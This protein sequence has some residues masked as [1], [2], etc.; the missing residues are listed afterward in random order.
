MIFDIPTIIIIVTI[1]FA[2]LVR[3]ATGFGFALVA[4]PILSFFLEP[5]EAVAY[6][7]IFQTISTLPIAFINFHKK[8]WKYSIKLLSFSLTGLIPSVILLIYIP[9][10]IVYALVAICVLVA[11]ILVATGVKIKSSL[12]LYHWFLVGFIA[13]FMHGLAGV[14]GPPILAILHADD[15]LSKNSKRQVMAIFFLFAGLLSLIPILIH[16]PDVLFDIN[17][18]GL[19]FFS[20][21]SGIYLGQKV[22][23][24]MSAS[25][26]H[27][28]TLVLMSIS[29]VLAIFQ[30]FK[31]T[32]II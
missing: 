8:E 3:T 10:V 17:L 29:S 26:F 31:F 32:K 27:I 28:C 7:M 13:G 19:L 25:Q 5:Q 20:M 24:S 1:F 18:L 21:I 2:S 15:T 30:L 22:F 16:S 12:N 9:I 11:L 23:T 14:S 4:I 6:T